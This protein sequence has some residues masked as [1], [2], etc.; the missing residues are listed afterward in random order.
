MAD[1]PAERTL[2]IATTN[3]GKVREI[4]EVLADLL[5]QWR[6]LSLSDLPDPPPSPA[7]T[8]RT[9]HANA[10]GKALYYARTTGLWA[11]ADDSGLEVEAL[12]GGPGLQSA[13]YAGPQGDAD[14]RNQKLLRALAA[15]PLIAT[16]Q[17][18]RTAPLPHRYGGVLIVA[19]A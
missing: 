11:L 7:E 18:V 16:P 13:R 4:A 15:V 8:G 5:G 3:P 10:Q 17:L 9:Y 19:D 6:F 2:L 14:A 1:R 12:N